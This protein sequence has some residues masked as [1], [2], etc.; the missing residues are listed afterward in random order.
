MVLE[1][2]YVVRHGVSAISSVLHLHKSTHLSRSLSWTEG[3]GQR[4]EFGGGSIEWSE[5]AWPRRRAG[6]AGE[7]SNGNMVSDSHQRSP[8]LARSTAPTG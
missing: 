3:K 2:I 6:T 5:L 7:M 4:Q 1:V 8:N